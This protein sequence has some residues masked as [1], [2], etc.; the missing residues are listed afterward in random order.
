MAKLISLEGATVTVPAGWSASAGYGIFSFNGYG[1][2][3]GYPLEGGSYFEEQSSINSF[4]IGYSGD[5]DGN[6]PQMANRIWFGNFG[7]IGNN[8]EFAI[9]IVDGR[10]ITNQSLI[11][12]LV[13][14]NA[15]I[16]GGI[17][18]ESS[19]TTYEVLYNDEVIATVEPG[20]KVEIHCAGDIMDYSLVVRPVVE[21]PGPTILAG[22]YIA[23]DNIE[24]SG[25][26]QAGTTS[27]SFTSNGTSFTSIG[28]DGT[29]MR[30]DITA[31]YY[32]TSD[33][34]ETFYWKWGNENYKTITLA[35]DQTVSAEFSEWF[36]ANYTQSDHS[37]GA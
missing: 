36:N 22:T 1:N 6:F 25:L 19:G 10:D 27:L 2:T 35:T 26:A 4:R 12:W 11:Q 5:F 30:Y 16:E 18:E 37:G 33:D 14:N 31:A 7:A 23:N 9:K 8:S 28:F 13:D 34:G 20:K 32:N 29:G 24:L 17:Y 3:D 15:T 21:E